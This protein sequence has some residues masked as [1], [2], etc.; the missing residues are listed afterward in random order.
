MEQTAKS[1]AAAGMIWSAVERFS[2]QGMQFVLGIIIARMLL[3]SDYG[4]IAMLA[5]F[6]AVSQAFIDSGFGY[7]LIQKKNRTEADFS[8]VFYFNIAIAVVI[9][10]MLF[11]AAPHIASFYNT[12]ELSFITK[13]V[14]ITLII[15]SFGI[16][17]QSRITIMLDFKKLA[18]ASLS[19]V[20]V[21]GIAGLIMAYKGYGAWA[22]IVQD[23]LNNIVRVAVIWFFSK[24]APRLI[25]S[26][27]SFK[28]LFSF[29]SK[30]LLSTLLHTIYTN[31]YSL[32]IGK[33]YTSSDLGFYNRAYTL[34][35]FPSTNFTSVI[36]RVVYPI[37]CRHQD[38]DFEIKTLFLKYMKMAC[39]IIFPMM[40]ALVAVAEPLI[41]T[42][43]TDVW[44]DAVPLL[45]ILSIA[46]MWDPIMRLNHSLI[47]AKGRSDY[48]LFA[49]VL[50]KT[51]GILILVATIPFGIKVMCTG[52]IVYAFADMGIIIFFNRKLTGLG[53]LKQ[54]RELFPIL[55]LS[56][57][58]GAF[59]Y[60]VIYLLS[61]ISPLLQLIAAGLA[62]GA[63]Y[64]TASKIFKFNEFEM[65]LALIR[66]KI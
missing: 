20:I 52:L 29:G 44:L 24:W 10:A 15:N 21:G 11:F 55:L 43:L 22:L 60:L 4:L 56:I 63:F 47:N 26:F 23:L 16:V 35:N 38:D 13:V 33:K 17:Q 46:F 30:L 57:F 9:Y 59:M 48:F 36:D 1:G 54:A 25:F 53:W 6:R 61:G 18:I 14:G 39:Y 2:V 58:M 45:Q 51:T 37:F 66:K 50:K 32:I 41:R 19:G 7:A 3:P 27:Q 64:W 49:E 65:L 8:T 42:L 40:I 34:A 62:G 28:T 31:I 5:I 12:P